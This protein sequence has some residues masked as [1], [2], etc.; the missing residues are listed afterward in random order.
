MFRGLVDGDG[1]DGVH[2]QQP[3]AE[4]FEVQNI[5]RN[6]LP[7]RLHFECHE[8]YD[9]YIFILNTLTVCVAPNWGT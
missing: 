5:D 4:P 3:C 8:L 2:A 9:A 6:R 7:K 1:D